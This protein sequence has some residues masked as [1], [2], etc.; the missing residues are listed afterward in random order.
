MRRACPRVFTRADPP[1]GRLVLGRVLANVMRESARAREYVFAFSFYFFCTLL[2]APSSSPLFF[3]PPLFSPVLL[4]PSSPPRKIRCFSRAET[5]PGR[6]W[7]GRR[8]VLK[9]D[10]QRGITRSHLQKSFLPISRDVAAAVVSCF[11]PFS[12]SAHSFPFSP[13]EGSTNT[14]IP[15]L[16]GFFPQIGDDCLRLRRDVKVRRATRQSR[17]G[18]IFRIITTT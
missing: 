17:L 1:F 15:R 16:H 4:S 11:S 18:R 13:I 10:V 8:A 12:V 9:S 2:S 14:V 5:T 3:R 6:I 7:A